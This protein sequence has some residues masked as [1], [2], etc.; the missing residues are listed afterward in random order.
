V[1]VRVAHS[2]ADPRF[3]EGQSGVLRR[4]FCALMRR[5]LV[6]HA[7][8]GLAVSREA[9]AGLYGAAWEADPRFGV[10]YCGID[11]GPFRRAAGPAAVRAALGLPAGAFVIG[12]VGRFHEAKNHPF[13]LEVAAEVRRRRPDTRLLIV[14]DGRLRPAIE[15][16]VRAWAWPTA[17]C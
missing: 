1:P 9:G 2:H 3:Q 12:H 10:L 16:K 8:I 17:R 7:T 14:G 5:W 15:E 4:L 13:L 11:L 6:R